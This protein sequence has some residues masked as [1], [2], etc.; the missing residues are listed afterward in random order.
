MTVVE[1]VRELGLLRAAGATRGQLTSYILVQATAIGVVGSLLGI[2]L[3][4][5]LAAGIAAWVRT[6]GIG[7][8]GG[9][10]RDPRPMPWRRSPSG[11]S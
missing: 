10:G 4:A 9:P 3:G 5:A 2:A 1:R 7:P 6:V 11:S 8:A